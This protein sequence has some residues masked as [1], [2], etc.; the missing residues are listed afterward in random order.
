MRLCLAILARLFFFTEDMDPQYSQNANHRDLGDKSKAS[1]KMSKLNFWFEKEGRSLPWRKEPTPY[2]VWVSEVMLQQTQVR[3][4][5]PYFRQWICRWPDIQSLAK[6]SVEDVIKVWEGLGYYSRARSLKKGAEYVMEKF[7]GSLPQERAALLEIPGIGPY[8][9]AA[10]L[11]FA[12]KKR[13]LALDGNVLRVLSRYFAYGQDITKARSKK[14]LE[15]LGA[16]LLDEARPWISAEALIELGALVC[17]KAAPQCGQCPLQA[18]CRGFAEGNMVAYPVRPPRKKVILLRRAV[19]VAQCGNHF[20]VIHHQG[21]G[22]MRD[23]FEFPFAEHTGNARE[24]AMRLAE[25]FGILSITDLSPQI[26]S[27]TQYKAELSP[28]LIEVARRNQGEWFKLKELQIR[29]LSS[30]HKRILQEL[31]HRARLQIKG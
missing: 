15:S 31:I 30:G 28:F 9:A 25:P 21:P 27:F 6:A 16:P 14:E 10:I 2:A 4:V 29:P 20:L 17:T 18:G 8:T 19:L 1:E 11:S 13:A 22:L 24:V 5:I 3:V 26:H 12:F 23:L 7:G